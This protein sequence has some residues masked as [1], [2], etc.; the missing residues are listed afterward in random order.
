M[1]SYD[2]CCR[3][4]V[5]VAK[6]GVRGEAVV[7]MTLSQ[8]KRTAL[9]GR[10]EP[11]DDRLSSNE[12]GSMPNFRTRLGLFDHVVGQTPRERLHSRT[13]HS[14]NCQSSLVTAAPV[15]LI[16]PP[17]KA[18]GGSVGTIGETST[19]IFGLRKSAVVSPTPFPG[20]TCGEPEFVGTLERTALTIN[21]L[22][23]FFGPR[24]RCIA[25]K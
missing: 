21:S 24:R 25:P 2:P 10:T 13:D 15:S 20:S 1:R 19:R 14:V 6:A 23:S 3:R 18:V 7:S 22:R 5:G 4:A 17:C 16:P 8:R 11:D 12:P 9:V